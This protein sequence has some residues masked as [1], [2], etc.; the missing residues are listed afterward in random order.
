MTN[1]L[2]NKIFETPLGKVACGLDNDF[3]SIETLGTNEYENGK[4]SVYKIIGSEYFKRNKSTTT[5]NIRQ[6]NG[7]YC[8][9]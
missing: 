7:V 8:N 5:H 3:P 6:K 9:R 2:I 1:R 4:S